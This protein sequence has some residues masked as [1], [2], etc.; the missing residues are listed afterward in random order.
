MKSMVCDRSPWL[1]RLVLPAAALLLAGCV[2]WQHDVVVKGVAFSKVRMAGADLAIGQI[3]EDTVIG[4]RP[5]KRGWVHV[6]GNGVP[7]AFTAAREIDLGR[8]KIPAETWV[9][10]TEKGVV[11]ICAFPPGD[12]AVQG[13][14]CRGGGWLGGGPE[15]I[16]AEFYPDG[17]LRKYFLS[18]DTR[19]Q[20][21]PCKAGLL[22]E[23]IELHESGRLKACVLSADLTRDGRT[24]PQGTRLRFD[25]DGRIMP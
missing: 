6:R 5:C 10:Q 13:H 17:A 11:K 9:I 25:P 18:H 7:V 2:N 21:I 12:T 16:Q 20:D 22:N 4:G 3:K 19:I 8:F 24:Y 14:L 1:T 15:G 23:I